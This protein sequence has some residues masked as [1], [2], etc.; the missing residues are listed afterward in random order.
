[1]FWSRRYHQQIVK[2]S[3]VQMIVSSFLINDHDL[4][5][6]RSSRNIVFDDFKRLKAVE[7]ADLR[8]KSRT[9]LKLSVLGVFSIF[10]WGKKLSSE[11]TYSKFYA[12]Y[13]AQLKKKIVGRLKWAKKAKILSTIFKRQKNKKIEFWNKW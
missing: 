4:Y 2:K 6:L 11:P 1:M 7:R 5:W 9:T 12:L 10:L 8:G 13:A 3:I